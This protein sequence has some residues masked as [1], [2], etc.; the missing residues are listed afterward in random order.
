MALT[1]RKISSAKVTPTKPAPEVEPAGTTLCAEVVPAAVVREVERC[2][3]CKKFE[4]WSQP[5]KLCYECWR[6]NQGYT[7]DVEQNRFVMEQK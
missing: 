3:R 4:V 5:K 2:K 7:F 1:R 6:E